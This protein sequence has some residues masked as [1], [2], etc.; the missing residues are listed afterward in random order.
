MLHGLN[1]VCVVEAERS[2]VLPGLTDICLTISLC[3]VLRRCS[4]T[5][6]KPLPDAAQ[7]HDARRRPAG[8]ETVLSL[9]HCQARGAGAALEHYSLASP[10]GSCTLTRAQACACVYVRECARGP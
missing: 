7:S 9:W 6:H 2:S 8:R 1:A 3:V 5:A 10:A 4:P